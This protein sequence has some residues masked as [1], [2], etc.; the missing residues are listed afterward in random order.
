[1]A[2]FAASEGHTLYFLGA[3]LGVAEEA[4]RQL[5]ER[6]PALKIAGFITAISITPP[7]VQRTTAL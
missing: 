7:E 6:F 4:T 2:A 3:P 5:T 1:L